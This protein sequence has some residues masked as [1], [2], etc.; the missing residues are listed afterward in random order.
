MLKLISAIISA[1]GTL[2]IIGWEDILGFI[3]DLHNTGPTWGAVITCILL[4]SKWKNH[5]QHR[6]QDERLEAKID[7]IARKV[8]AECA[9]ESPLNRNMGPMRSLSSPKGKSL[10]LYVTSFIRLMETVKSQLSRRVAKVNL[11]KAWLVGLLG[12]IFYF[13]KMWTG[14]EL[15]EEM[16]DKLADIIL[17]GITI[18]A[19]I[20]NIKGGKGGKND[21][22]AQHQTG[23]GPA[24]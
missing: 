4:W 16:M 2:L 19:M 23:G 3:G 21:E 20:A 8:G 10:A 12:Y 14:F 13:V 15:P 22:S 9:E 6:A 5:K 24:V 11:S 18:A 17:L 7:A 1:I